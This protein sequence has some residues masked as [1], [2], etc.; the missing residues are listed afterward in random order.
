MSQDIQLIIPMTGVGQR[1]VDRGYTDIKPLIQTGMGSM[2]NGVLRNF[3]SITSQMC[4][5]S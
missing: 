3:Q 1:F 2:L 5:I 4:I